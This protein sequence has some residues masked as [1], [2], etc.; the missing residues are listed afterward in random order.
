MH[1]RKLLIVILPLLGFQCN[2]QYI[3]QA[4]ASGVDHRHVDVSQIGGGIAVFDLNNDG[5]E[6]LYLTGGS[7]PDKLFLN[8]GDGTFT[9]ISASSAILSIAGLQTVGVTTGDIDNDGDRDI[10]VTTTRTDHNILFLNNGDTTFT[11]ISLSAGIT[12]TT[13]STSVTMGDYNN[14]GYL[15]IYVANYAEYVTN[16]FFLTIS[17]GI[18][19]TLYQNNG[20]FTFTDVS[21]ASGTSD[22][23]T[24]LAVAFTDFD[25]DQD[26]DLLLGN[27]FGYNYEPNALFQNNYP[28]ND[29]SNV[30]STTF[31]DDEI[32]AMGIAIGDF[33]E[34]GDFDYYISNMMGNLLH[35]RNSG[36][37]F[38]ESAFTALVQVDSLV[39][40]GTFFFDYDNDTYLDLFV[41]NGGVMN[42]SEPQENTLFENQQDGTFQNVAMTTGMDSIRRSRGAVYAD[43]NNDGKLE[44][45]VANVGQN[46]STSYNTS[47]YENTGATGNHWVSLQL[48]GT[49]CNADAY[50]A[51]VTLHSNGRSWLREI[52]GGS[53][54]LSQNSS[55][56]HFGLGNYTSIDSVIVEWPGGG[57]DIYL[58]LGID[59][60]HTLTQQTAAISTNDSFKHVHIYPNP[61]D[62]SV[63]IIQSAGHYDFVEIIDKNGSLLQTQTISG[64]KSE[65]DISTFSPGI[66]FVRLISSEGNE[67]HKIVKL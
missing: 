49:F 29:F 19:N 52:G 16:P 24:S 58:G 23:G 43:F 15:D 18:G 3:E 25:S 50:G 67:T 1:Y 41:A 31:T 64:I 56:A 53:S 34:D 65:L 55:R 45:V 54:Y 28:I 61:T 2:A 40:W 22:L 14:D 11:D 8:D 36:M 20:D 44:L 33:D 47:I 62:N 46:Y 38:S 63:T 10:F 4:I 57:T 32:D 66:Y 13:W 30:A 6:D 37:T 17:S 27:D 26:V 12:D 5:F 51:H 7:E 42:M 59:Q 21:I 60:M 39:S 35:I 48:S 9:D